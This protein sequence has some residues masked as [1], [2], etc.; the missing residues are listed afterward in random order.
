MQETKRGSTPHVGTLEMGHLK[1]V[2][3]AG[4]LLLGIPQ[5]ET[6]AEHS[7]RVGVVGCRR[8]RRRPCR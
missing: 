7:F 2:T 4:W 6:V 1:H 3:R 8:T 5:P